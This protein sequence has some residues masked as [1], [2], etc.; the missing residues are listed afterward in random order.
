MARVKKT[1]LITGITGQDG[2]YLAEFLLSKKYRVAGIEQPGKK[3][4]DNIAALVDRIELF[5]G[6]LADE[7]RIFSLVQ[8]IRPDEIY[9]LASQS[10]ATASFQKPLETADINGVGPVRM[11]EAIRRVDPRIRFF[12][13]SSAE[14]FGSS[15]LTHSPQTED[16]PY[17][18]VS[19]YGAAKLYAHAMVRVYR[20]AHRLFAVSGILFNHE[21]PRRGAEFVT[22]KISSAAAAIKLGRLR[23]LRLGNLSVSRDW[24]FAGDY[25]EAM[26]RSLQDPKARD[27]VIATGES[28]TVREFVEEAFSHLGLDW[29]KF[30]KKDPRFVRERERYVPCGDASAAR[31]A[32]GWKPKIGFR[33]L[34]RMMVDADL[35]LLQSGEKKG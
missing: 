12:Q 29:K 16:T 30:V 18:P 3:H 5:A 19:P 13:A 4:R 15:T 22:R 33:A 34:V 27:Y 23:E 26:W 1:A 8:R 11:I 32:L 9:N 2:S 6:D 25:V 14:I 31:A 20:E 17:A 10:S 28:H 21:S 7:R 35:K 24:G